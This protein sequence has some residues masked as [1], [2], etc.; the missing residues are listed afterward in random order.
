MIVILIVLVIPVIAFTFWFIFIL[1]TAT[2]FW[3]ESD[4]GLNSQCKKS[5][6]HTDFLTILIGFGYLCGTLIL[7][8]SSAIT[9]IWLIWLMKKYLTALYHSQKYLIITSLLLKSW[10]ICSLLYRY[11]LA[12]SVM[13]YLT[14][15]SEID[16]G[17]IVLL[18]LKLTISFLC[19]IA[20]IFFNIQAVHVERYMLTMLSAKGRG[21]YLDS[22]SILIWSKAHC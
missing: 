19:P 11:I 4:K 2:N 9:G 14:S 10:F 7:L 8:I 13:H 1:A 16:F 6:K 17:I 15:E 12:N 22:R 3:I 21:E 20:S 5:S 18:L